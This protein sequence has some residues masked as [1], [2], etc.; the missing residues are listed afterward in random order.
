MYCVYYFGSSLQRS[1]CPNHHLRKKRPSLYT[2]RRRQLLPPMAR[3]RIPN[4]H[5]LGSGQG[6]ETS[7]CL[8]RPIRSCS[9]LAYIDPVNFKGQVMGPKRPS[10][11]LF[12]PGN[13]S[14]SPNI[15]LR[16]TVACAATFCEKAEA[17]HVSNPDHSGNIALAEAEDGRTSE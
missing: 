1:S 5:M 6:R 4:H 9:S 16:I 10:F 2:G 11:S 12:L 15:I 13:T 7:A 8:T 17:L 14:K 3:S